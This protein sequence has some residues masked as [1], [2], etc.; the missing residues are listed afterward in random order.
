MYYTH[1]HTY[2]LLRTNTIEPTFE[3]SS[4]FVEILKSALY[5]VCICV[6]ICIYTYNLPRT[7]KKSYL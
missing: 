2:N 3:D 6:Y 5:C 1:I 7:K 4:I